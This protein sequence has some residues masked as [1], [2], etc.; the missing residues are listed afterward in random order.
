MHDPRLALALLAAVALFVALA[1]ALRAP[2][3]IVLVVGGIAVGAIPGVPEVTLSPEVVFYIFLP[4]L[5]YSAALMASTRELRANAASI[6]Q[7]AIGLVLLSTAAVGLA[8]HALGALPW[9]AALTLGGVL[10]PTDPVSAV[11]LLRGAPIRERVI[12]ILEGES[13]VN[14][15]TGLVVYSLAIGAAGGAAV[16]PLHVGIQFVAI[17]IGGVLVGIVVGTGSALAR[18]GLDEPRLELCLSLLTPF[19][20]YLGADALGASGVLSAVAA[21]VLVG[22]AGPRIL[23]STTRLRYRAFWDTAEFLLGSTLFLLL[24]LQLPRALTNLPAGEIDDAVTLGAVAALAIFAVRFAWMFAVAPVLTLRTRLSARERLILSCSGMR[25]GVAL[26]AALAIP[27]TAGG[28]PFPERDMVLAA[29]FVAITLT[30]VAPAVALRAIAIRTRG[31]PDSGE[32]LDAAR[33]TLRSAAID[34]VAL[35]R[36]SDAMPAAFLDDVARRLELELGNDDRDG[37]AARAWEARVGAERELVAAQREALHR[38]QSTGQV[39]AAQAR[40]LERELD[41]ED[42]RLLPTGAN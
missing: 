42:A 20:A 11:A 24:G 39:T 41:L 38:L 15:G 27:L 34:R 22:R 10:A 6:G 7:L 21:G 14:D 17:A 36:Q 5:V 13:L 18:R 29:S 4:P 31:T 3:P 23:T 25:G 19:A 12:T 35:L 8:A 28:T 9:V 1:R 33:R 32:E 30:L 2:P 16:V 37:V 26:A 40:L